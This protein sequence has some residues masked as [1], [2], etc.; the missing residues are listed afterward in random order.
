MTGLVLPAPGQ[1]LRIESGAA[2]V[3]AM[4]WPATRCPG[5]FDFLIFGH[6]AGH[7]DASRH[8]VTAAGVPL[9]LGALD[10]PAGA[11]WCAVEDGDADLL[12]GFRQEV[13]VANARRI[14]PPGW[15][16]RAGLVH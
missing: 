9:F 1:F 7:R 8:P 3:L 13:L 6:R 14:P 15:V 10:R 12:D 2:G 16:V 5:H 4:I 11:L